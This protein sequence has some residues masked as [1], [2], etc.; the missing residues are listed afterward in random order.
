MRKYLNSIFESLRKNRAHAPMYF[1]NVSF[2]TFCNDCIQTKM[3]E[4]NE[5]DKQRMT[6]TR[7]SH[8]RVP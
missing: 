5:K 6:T 3:F 7:V 8:F 4:N 1:K 2:N